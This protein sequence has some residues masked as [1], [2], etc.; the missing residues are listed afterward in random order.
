MTRI[1]NGPIQ[2]ALIVENPS[3]ELDSH[4][5]ED[6]LSVT[7]LE[8]VP[9][10]E[11][12]ISTINR[13]GAQ[14]VFKRSRVEITR[15]VI[16]ACPELL[17]VQLC[18]IGDDSVDK[19]ACADAGIMV[20]ND[21]ISNGRSVVELV[22]GHLI[23]LSRRLHETNIECRSGVWA[24]NNTDRY[25]IRGKVLGILGLG[26]IGRS[27]ARVAEA[28]GMT[29]VFHDSREVAME[30]GVEMGW[31]YIDS[32]SSLFKNSD[33]LSVHLSAC[34]VNG[35]S[36]A[37]LLTKDTLY[38][39]GQNRP[40]SSPRVFLNLSRGFLHTAQH[41]KDAV[42]DGVIRRAAV[43][44]YPSEPRLGQ[45]WQNP[46]ASINN[47]VVTPHIGASTQEAQPR[48]ARR[49]SDTFRGFSRTGVLRDCVFEP[50]MSLNLASK[51][52]SGNVMLAVMHSTA[53]GTKR[54]IDDAIYQAGASNLASTHKDFE[55]LG[56]AYDLALLDAPL[57]LDQ[58][59]GLIRATRDIVGEETAIRSVRQVVVN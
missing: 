59:D 29:V 8:K 16:E 33:Y 58:I 44:V 38:S 12:L 19:Q 23:S 1:C 6:G 49:V 22:F 56:V 53:R 52:V 10:Q 57:S 41:L 35:Q 15:A 54:A 47:I 46:Y 34:D 21:P 27:V 30:V 40:E 25:E 7:R 51:L 45:E 4:L 17:A 18:C 39:L 55:H 48:I 37:H 13:I 43:D 32:V 26:N 36:N 9:T 3:L 24:K 14:V 42:T 2:R 28:L 11:E 20:L 50:R 5:R 31:S